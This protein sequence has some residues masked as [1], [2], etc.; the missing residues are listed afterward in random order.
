M[1][2]WC[3]NSLTVSGDLT[4]F[5]DVIG[6]DNKFSFNKFN[7]M[8]E[9]LENS[10]CVVFTADEDEQQKIADEKARLL[11]KYGA[12]GWYDWNCQNIGCKWDVEGEV[13][14]LGNSALIYFDSPW[15][16]PLDGVELLSRQ[17]PELEFKLDYFEPGMMFA[18][19]ATAEEGLLVDN[20]V[21][22]ENDPLWQEV[23]VEGFQYDPSEFDE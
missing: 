3:N 8:P 23:A 12:S 13:E 10:T 11:E 5:L 14:T 1:P 20:C 9:E 18:G 22:D 19:R 16:P 4:K 17:F 7:P 6:E 2:N 21:G 15:S